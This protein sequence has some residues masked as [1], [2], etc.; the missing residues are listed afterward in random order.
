MRRSTHL[1]LALLTVAWVPGGCEEPTRNGSG[2]RDDGGKVAACETC[3]DGDGGPFADL[4]RRSAGDGPDSDRPG[5]DGQPAPDSGRADGAV[6]PA[7][8]A[9]PAPRSGIWID[10]SEI[11]RL[12]TSGKPWDAVLRLAQGSLGTAD[13]SDQDSS[14]DVKTLAAALACARLDDAALCA[15]ARAAVVSA[16]GT[17]SG[18][19]WLAVGRNLTAYVI[20]ADVLELRADGD[21]SSDGSRVEAWIAQFLTRTLQH[22]NDANQQLPLA[23]FASGSN[24]SAQ[25][26]AAY[27]AVAAYLKDATALARAWDA[28]RTYACEPGAP[29]NENIILS[30]G[31]AYGWAHDDVHPCAVNP[32]GTKK[33][34]PSGRPGAGS[35]RRID[36]AVINDMRRGG[37][38]AWPPGYTPYPWVGLEG[39]VPAALLLHRAGYPAFTVADRAV[40][41]TYEY[42]WF[43][44]EETGEIEW[45]D[46]S[47]ADETT[48][49]VNVAY[50]TS[51]P[52]QS[53][54]GGGRT[55]GFTDWTH[56]TGI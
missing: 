43:L 25:E 39:F 41:R 24:A 22:N 20:A 55:V 30:K 45:F 7:D 32:L 50:G 21:P 38:Y 3:R 48:H 13:V 42:L 26:G 5:A 49:L 23:P 11:A 40:L 10:P 6:G 46:G 35:V 56:P 33:K 18:G 44:R 1:N 8:D 54:V 28:F 16:I 27:A 12:P 47:R 31:V 9:H 29:D 4:A 15:K 2:P 37:E 36:G 53:A 51:F 17:E 34:V 14:H 19:R 52:T